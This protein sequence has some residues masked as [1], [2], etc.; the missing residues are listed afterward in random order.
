MSGDQTSRTF[1]ENQRPNGVDQTAN[2]LPRAGAGRQAWAGGHNPFGIFKPV[3]HAISEIRVRCA[4]AIWISFSPVALLSFFFAW[5]PMLAKVCSATVNGNE[6]Y[7]VEVEVNAGF[8]DTLVMT[9]AANTPQTVW[10]I[11]N[12]DH[13]K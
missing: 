11:R 12:N 5:C 13:V 4:P 9:I 10:G 3:A 6:A 2:H 1:A 7:P 8:G